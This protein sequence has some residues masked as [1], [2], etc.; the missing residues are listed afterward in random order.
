MKN[1]PWPLIVHTTPHTASYVLAIR[2]FLFFLSFV[3]PFTPGIL[4][5]LFQPRM[6]SYYCYS[7]LLPVLLVSAGQSWPLYLTSIP[8][9]SP[10]S[11]IFHS[12]KYVHFL[13]SVL[14]FVPCFL[15]LITYCLPSPSDCKLHENRVHF[16]FTHIWVF[17]MY[18]KLTSIQWYPDLWQV[19]MCI[20][21]INESRCLCDLGQIT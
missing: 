21:W 18:S 7:W 3:Y 8:S 14:D 4:Y 20:C 19:L 13:P 11:S 15:E 16:C 9:L 5:R 17:T 6:L 10:F 12:N 2:S 1:V